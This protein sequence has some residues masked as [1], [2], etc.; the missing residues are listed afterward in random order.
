MRRVAFTPVLLAMAAVAS[1][2][3]VATPDMRDKHVWAKDRITSAANL[4]TAVKRL[5]PKRSAAQ[6]LPTFNQDPTPIIT[7]FYGPSSAKPE[8]KKSRT[9]P[10][11][12]PPEAAVFQRTSS[13]SR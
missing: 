11:S 9:A 7:E 3:S 10:P 1:S 4:P 12:A 13:R 6:S 5:S 2:A 8:T